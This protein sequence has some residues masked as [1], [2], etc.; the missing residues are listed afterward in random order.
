MEKQIETRVE[1]KGH[2]FKK[3]DVKVIKLSEGDSVEG[4]LIAK[5]K[6]PWVNTETGQTQDLTRLHFKDSRG[7]RFIIFEDGGLRN[8]LA[9]ANIEVG[10]LLKITKLPKIELNDG[11]E[12]NSYEI[13]T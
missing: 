5:T 10:A 1:K 2:I 8:A 7:T 12:V 9:N 4:T 3:V 11:R 6:S 13:Y